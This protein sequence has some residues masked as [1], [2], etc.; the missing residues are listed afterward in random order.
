MRV[1]CRCNVSADRYFSCLAESVAEDMRQATGKDV[2]ASN[3]KS[4]MSYVKRMK[5]KAGT[6]SRVRVRI[7]EFE[8]PYAYAATFSS[9]QGVNSIAYRIR[10]EGE[11]IAVGY[12]E[13]F[14]GATG[15][16]R[17][18][19]QIM[20]FFYLFGA[21]RRAKKQLHVIELYA[22]HRPAISEG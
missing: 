17:A 16:S 5:T 2:W 6:E 9:S 18:N 21:R 1:E 13:E 10:E 3:L 8:W 14:E 22:A 4:G 19:Y 7:V 20:E 15:K 11:G 12:S